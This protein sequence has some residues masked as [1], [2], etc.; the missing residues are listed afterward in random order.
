VARIE[1]RIAVAVD[2]A[3]DVVEVLLAQLP[4][5]FSPGRGWP[6]PACPADQ[7]QLRSMMPHVLPLAGTGVQPIQRAQR[8][9][10][11]ADRVEDGVEQAI[12]LPS[13]LISASWPI[14]SWMEV[15]WSTRSTAPGGVGRWPAAPVALLPGTDVERGQAARW[16]RRARRWPG[17][18]QGGVD[19]AQ[20]LLLHRGDHR[21]GQ[22][23]RGLRNLP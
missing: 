11:V 20:L 10:L 22:R 2:G 13:S 8:A 12:A 5:N 1:I 15:R 9:Q 23:L 7:G 4:R 3:G 19:F 6:R 21:Q 14:F 18:V 17:C 16:R